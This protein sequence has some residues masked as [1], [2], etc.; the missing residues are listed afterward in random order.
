MVKE[1]HTKIK[2]TV[3]IAA[4][5]LPAFSLFSLGWQKSI[6]S[7]HQRNS[8]SNRGIL[9]YQERNCLRGSSGSIITW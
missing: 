3:E 4:I 7:M 6:K 2:F 9:F 5:A 8:L 1:M